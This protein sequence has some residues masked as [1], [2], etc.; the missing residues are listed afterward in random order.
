MLRVRHSALKWCEMAV[1]SM[2]LV[3]LGDRRVIQLSLAS[4]HIGSHAG[5]GV[6]RKYKWTIVGK[7]GEFDSI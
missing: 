7:P 4:I 3:D 6:G 2:P 5:M 1:S